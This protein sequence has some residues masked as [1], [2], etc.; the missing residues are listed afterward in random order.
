MRAATTAADVWRAFPEYAAARWFILSQ[1]SKLIVLLREWD[2]DGDGCI[3][4]KEFRDACRVRLLDAPFR[5]RVPQS[6]L[7]ELY[8]EMDLDN[9]Q[10][11]PLDDLITA[12][13]VMPCP[14][15]PHDWQA[16]MA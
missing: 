11:M 13:R 16:V 12:L 10:N 3:S 5:S 7:D 4:P 8:S 2:A 6:T 15:E 1:Q 14:E 9:A